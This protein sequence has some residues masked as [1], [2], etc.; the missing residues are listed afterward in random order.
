MADDAAYIRVPISEQL[1]RQEDKIDKLELE[2][3]T[4]REVI[5]RRLYAIEINVAA[6]KFSAA[7]WG[8]AMGLSFSI[9]VLW[10]FEVIN[11]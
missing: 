8:A 11:K 9:V 2:V 6:I 1:R 7:G 3:R 4:L 10:V 5:D